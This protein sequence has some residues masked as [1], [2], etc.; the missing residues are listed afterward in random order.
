MSSLNVS[1]SEVTEAFTRGAKPAM[2]SIDLPETVTVASS[3]GDGD[4]DVDIG[5]CLGADLVRI[6]ELFRLS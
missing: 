3:P 1:S 5:Q 6:G 4:V 2:M